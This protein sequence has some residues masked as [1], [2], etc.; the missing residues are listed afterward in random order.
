VQF[1]LHPWRYRV[2]ICP[3]PLRKD[4]EPVVGL[5]HARE[6]LLCGTLVARERLE[7]LLDQ[8]RKLREHHHGPLAP[9][10]LPSFMADMMRQLLSQGGEPALARLDADG[11]I[12]AGGAEQLTAE[13]VGCEC[14]KCGTRY[15]AHQIATGAP[16]FRADV[17]RLV[18]RRSVECEFCNHVMSWS[19]GTTG[20]GNPNGRIMSGPFYSRP[21]ATSPVE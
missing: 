12:D 8:L 9:E 15:G 5:V 16:E 17:G 13:P 3:G 19:E 18:L 11:A 21:H 2:R 10:Y 6:I 14:G 7:V 20:A 4:G 1:N